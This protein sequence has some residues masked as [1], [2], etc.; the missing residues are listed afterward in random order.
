MLI[1]KLP[2]IKRTDS[3]A[4]IVQTFLSPEEKEQFESV[5]EELGL[6]M[7]HVL[8]CLAVQF[9]NGCKVND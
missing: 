1:E 8:R 9:A 2:H 5:C 7:T 6:K 3:G 4:K